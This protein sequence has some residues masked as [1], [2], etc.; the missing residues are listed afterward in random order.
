[1]RLLLP[2]TAFDVAYLFDMENQE[3]YKFHQEKAPGSFHEN[4]LLRAFYHDGI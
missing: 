2:E 3:N 4:D 1:M